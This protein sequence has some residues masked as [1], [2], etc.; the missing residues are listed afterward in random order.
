MNDSD[1]LQLIAQYEKAAL[2]SPVAAGATVGTVAFSA[3][4]QM[5]TLEIDRFNALNM[6][7]ARPLGNEIENS[8]QVVLPELRDTVEWIMPQLMRVFVAARIPCV[9]EPENEQDVDQAEL[10][11]EAVRHVLMV[12]NEGF[13]VIH[14]YAKDALLLRNGY[15]QV[16][17]EKRKKTVTESYSGL[18]EQA[19]T[20][21]LD[22][23]E[24][25]TEILE[26]REYQQ[27]MPLDPSQPVQP[28]QQPQPQMITVFDVKIRRKTE[29]G[30]VCVECL[31]PEEVLVSNRAKTNL[32]NSP[33][34]EHKCTWT[35]SDLIADGY[36]ADIVNSLAPG[37]P[38]WLEMDALARDVVT[39]QLSVDENSADRA[40]Q[41]IEV[42]DVTIRVDYDGDGIAELRHV[43]V[44]G[45]KILDNEE[46]EEVPIASGVPKRMPHRHTGISM[47]DELADIQ[48]IKSELARQGLNNLRLANNGRVAV[49]WK[50][51]NL[52]DLMTSRAGGVVRTNGPPGNVIMPF[53]HP[54]NLMEQVVP[55]MQYVDKWREFRTGVGED[56]VMPDADSLQNVTMGGQLAGMAAAGL[57]IE[58]I[59]RCLAEGLKDVMLKIRAMLV[60]HQNQPLNFRMRGKWVTVDPTSWRE[61]RRTVS[62]NVGLGSGNRP[63]A[64]QNLMLLGQAMGQV[65][66]LVSPKQ[67]Y[68]A[69]KLLCSVLGFDQPE[70]FAMDPSTPEF[71]QWQQQNRPPPPPQVQVAQIRAQ[72]QQQQAR[73]DA[74]RAQAEVQA[75]DARAQAEITH[76]ALQNREDRMVTMS[77]QDSQM[78]IDLAK[79]LAQIVSSQLKGDPSA[80]AG[81]VLRQDVQSLEGRA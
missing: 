71:Q 42:R 40:M 36:S 21:L 51:C 67:K 22:G 14:D 25:E 52:T 19:L 74:A 73:A 68:N 34:V 29:S 47:Y 20:E 23:K 37:R 48:V 64:R 5:T 18:T 53:E 3:T 26:Q 30:Q 56:T 57:K 69:F 16:Y 7:F 41:E 66:E 43:L 61:D 77:Q 78:F 75:A 4:Q 31:P 65:P 50:N 55:M 12:Q 59:A 9:F 38:Q 80:N 54:S 1:L 79:I 45:D 58:L 60:R 27:A 81:A 2:G 15:I 11:T 63:E 10:E 13:F 17:W 72:S 39:D 24:D 62:P 49:D 33:F 46:I 70:Q 8:S 6:Y 28:G 32:D 76:A 44:A 35:R